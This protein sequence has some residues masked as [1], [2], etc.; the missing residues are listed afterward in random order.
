MEKGYAMYYLFLVLIFTHG[1][2]FPFLTIFESSYE[3]T[4]WKIWI[5]KFYFGYVK[6][7]MSIKYPSAYGS[8]P[9]DIW[10][11]YSRERGHG[12]IYTWRVSTMKFWKKMRCQMIVEREKRWGSGLCC[13]AHQ[14]RHEV[15]EK[16]VVVIE[17]EQNLGEV[18]V[19]Q[20]QKILGFR[21]K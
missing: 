13:R 6:F 11:W 18:P 16:I 7:E 10:I 9:L 1:S 17:K 3:L 14:V 20:V 19:M 15:E 8:T 5:P 12:Q 21:K 4:M 2:L